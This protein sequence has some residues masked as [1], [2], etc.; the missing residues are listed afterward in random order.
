[1]GR[2]CPN[3]YARGVHFLANV[4]TNATVL[5]SLV[6][7]SAAKL[8]TKP[9]LGDQ[10]GG[11]LGTKPQMGRRCMGWVTGGRGLK[12]VEKKS[13][14]N[15]VCLVWKFL[16]DLVRVFCTYLEPPNSHIEQNPKNR[17][18]LYN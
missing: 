16:V 2:L 9:L 1:M 13:S 5:G 4:G 10:F 15:G 7:S 17:R 11:K 3:G 12:K 8:D 6:S 14:Q 18:K